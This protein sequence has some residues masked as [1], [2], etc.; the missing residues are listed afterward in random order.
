MDRRSKNIIHADKVKK[1]KRK[2]IFKKDIK[3]LAV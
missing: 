1:G 3:D 2:N